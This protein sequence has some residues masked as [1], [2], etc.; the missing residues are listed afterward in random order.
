MN[1]LSSKK[2]NQ[3]LNNQAATSPWVTNWDLSLSENK[4]FLTMSFKK[5]IENGFIFGIS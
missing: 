2:N 4:I 5:T 3:G 1:T